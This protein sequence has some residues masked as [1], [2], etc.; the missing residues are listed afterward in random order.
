[1]ITHVK[2]VSIPVRDQDRA[3]KFYTEKLGF[4]VETDVS[5]DN[6]QRWIKLVI[7]TGETRVVLFTPD[8][9]DDRIGTFSNVVFATTDVQKAYDDLREK[10]VEFTTAPTAEEW[11]TYA[12]FNDSEGNSFV[13]SSSA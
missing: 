10:G 4:K 1:M 8:G 7:P 6:C 13:L 2:L 3:L 5:V 12:Q 11:G 9:Q